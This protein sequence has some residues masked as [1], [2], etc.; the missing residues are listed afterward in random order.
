MSKRIYTENDYIVKCEELNLEYVCFNKNNGDTNIQFI[1]PKHRNKGIQT[2]DWGHLNQSAF[3]CTYCS[4]RNK[5]T[6]DFEKEILNQY[7]H[8]VQDYIGAEKPMYCYCE[9]CGSAW[10]TN[11]PIDLRKRMGGCPTCGKI[12]RGL[13]HRKTHFQFVEEMKEVNPNIMVIGKYHHAHQLIK[14]KCIIHDYEW[15]SYGSNL[16]NGT[17]GCPICNS[18]SGEVE[19]CSV[20]D[21]LNVEY[22]RQKSFPDCRDILPLKFDA[23]DII[24]NIA[25][26]FQGEQHYFPVDFTFNDP[27]Q[28]KINFDNL[29]RRDFIKK[30]YCEEN[31]I[32]LVCIPYWYRNHVK[33]YILSQIQTYN[34]FTLQ[35]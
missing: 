31:N 14:C 15:E 29:K 25:F 16:L 35:T 26:E 12:I 9:L 8:P 3:G 23:F 11:R 5:T 28:A 19:L 1:C 7:I 32:L 10:R 34:D 22:V 2:K 20:L 33:E 6:E 30:K 24:N 4:G 27:E 13:N 17:A 21:E 18:S